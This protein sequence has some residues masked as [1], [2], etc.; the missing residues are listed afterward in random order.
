M[1]ISYQYANRN[2]TS[3]L[4][5]FDGLINGQTVC[6][7]IDSGEGVDVDNLIDEDRG[8]YL[9]GILLTHLH[10]DHYVTLDENLQDGAKI[11]TSSE[12][13]KLLDTV[14]KEANSNRTHSLDTTAIKRATTPIGSSMAIGGGLTIT[15]VPA[16][17]T[18]G[19]TSFYIQFENQGETE[20]ILVTGDFTRR[21]VGGYP[22]L[23]LRNTD[24]L[25][26][27]GATEE[28]FEETI[29]KTISKALNHSLSGSPTLITTSGLNSVHL[30][31]VLG[32]AINRSP[33]SVLV[34]IV[35]QAAKLY[36]TLNY[37][38]PN[39]TSHPKYSPENVLGS[40]VITI[41][42]PDI[43]KTGG[44][45]IL[46]DR[47][48]HNQNA[49][50]IQLISSNR[51]DIG[52]YSCTV[53]RYQ[54]INH[55]SETTLED[56][57]DILNPQQTIITHQTGSDLKA[58]REQFASIVWAPHNN[59]EYT[60]FD[61]NEWRS[62]PWVSNSLLEKYRREDKQTI[63]LP[64]IQDEP[65]TFERQEP[66]LE[67][68]GINVNKITPRPTEKGTTKY[69]TQSNKPLNETSTSNN[70]KV[71]T[72]KS[73]LSS[74]QPEDPKENNIAKEEFEAI[75]SNL[76]KLEAQFETQA[77]IEATVIKITDN[78]I[79]LEPIQVD[80]TPE[81]GDTVRIKLN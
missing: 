48:R 24:C 12:N 81:A 17:H 21:R 59:Q 35:G 69:S 5:K 61:N 80:K 7:L 32:H 47:I 76:D 52:E 9:T 38:V 67:T 53:D 18:P 78:T 23:P 65:L 36:D 39:V 43:P 25:I 6:L 75:R 26:L 3:V 68:E 66:D 33:Q 19:A 40:E 34:N 16:G 29:T 50:L 72:G 51:A 11:Y 22:G 4:L 57:V 2:N 49:A 20:T 42:G 64:D 45:K 8:E 41:S 27:T 77:E 37:D 55:P 70:T 14:L 44:A 31:Y 73:V 58:Y 10:Q 46:F 62:P 56:L 74:S 13:A 63:T 71:R 28:S 60:I 79:V 1:N 54:F 30:A 15:P